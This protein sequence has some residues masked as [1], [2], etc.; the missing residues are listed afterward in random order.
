MMYNSCNSLMQLATNSLIDSLNINPEENIPFQKSYPIINKIGVKFSIT[1]LFDMNVSEIAKDLYN[2]N[3]PR[4]TDIISS[5]KLTF[6]LNNSFPISPY[7]II[8][9]ISL[10][11]LGNEISLHSSVTYSKMSGIGLLMFDCVYRPDIVY[12]NNLTQTINLPFFKYNYLNLISTSLMS[13]RIKIKLKKNWEMLSSYSLKKEKLIYQNSQS[14]L[15]N[16]LYTN[17]IISAKGEGIYINNRTRR[18]LASHDYYANMSVYYEKTYIIPNNTNPTLKLND[19]KIFKGKSIGLL[20]CCFDKNDCII[21]A[22]DT[23]IL[24]INN[25]CIKGNSY[26]LY[27]NNKIKHELTLPQEQNIQAHGVGAIFFGKPEIDIIYGLDFDNILNKVVL[28]VTI[29][30]EYIK[31]ISKIHILNHCFKKFLYKYG[32]LN[33]L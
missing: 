10:H 14:Q 9:K 23:Y 7:S 30:P 33:E 25:K 15:E 29:K 16:K 28:Y 24:T 4:Y 31:D 2:L 1:D 22:I 21:D 32:G 5:V 17:N 18:I 27:I 13:L 12:Y 11:N 26:D 3:I 8:D 20:I 19:N 6:N